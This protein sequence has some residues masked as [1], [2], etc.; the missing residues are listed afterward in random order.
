M[1]SHF[2]IRVLYEVL[3]STCPNVN[4]GYILCI[5]CRDK[6]IWDKCYCNNC[7]IYLIYGIHIIVD[8]YDLI[9]YGIME[10]G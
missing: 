5:V 7:I 4:N 9:K 2:P 1:V 6:C 3:T 10:V 8:F